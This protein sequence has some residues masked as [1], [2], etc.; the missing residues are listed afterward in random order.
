MPRRDRRAVRPSAHRALLMLTKRSTGAG[1][2]AGA[3]TGATEAPAAPV[4][5]S[6][7]VARDIAMAE[8]GSDSP[9]VLVRGGPGWRWRLSRRRWRRLSWCR[10]RLSWWRW[11][12]WRWRE[13]RPRLRQLVRR[14][15]RQP[16]QLQSR[17]FQRQHRQPW[18]Q[19]IQP[20]RQCQWQL[21]RI[22][23]LWRLRLGRCRRRCGGWCRRRR[24]SGHAELLLSDLSVVL[25]VSQLSELWALMHRSLDGIASHMPPR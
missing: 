14:L 9:L 21:W 16:R 22:R 11:L 23:R 5:A 4:A 20:Q 7:A 17:Q 24:R 12:P 13:F 2:G 10:R 19:H 25:P 18:R 15:G 1:A 6:G 8:P 3:A